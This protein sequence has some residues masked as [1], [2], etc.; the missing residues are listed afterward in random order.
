MK[1]PE[2]INIP[3]LQPEEEDDERIDCKVCEDMGQCSRCAR[4]T[5]RNQKTSR[6]QQ[7]QADNKWQVLR[8]KALELQ[9]K[10]EK[11]ILLRKAYLDKRDATKAELFYKTG[12]GREIIAGKLNNYLL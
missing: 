12:Y 3:A 6:G 5:T 11:I 2:S 1:H 4:G 8:K 7:G 9:S 10:R